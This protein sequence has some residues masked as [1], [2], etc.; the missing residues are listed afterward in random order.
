MGAMSKHPLRAAL[1]RPPVAHD[2][3]LI[4]LCFD[5]T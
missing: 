4:F 3:A 5:P 2:S 1:R